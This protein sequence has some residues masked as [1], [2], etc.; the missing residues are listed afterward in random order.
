M[1]TGRIT[2]AA[3]T[4]AF[5]LAP[6]AL[7]AQTVN[8][9]RLPG[10][11]T[12]PNPKAQGP[13]DPDAP[14]L[15]TTP[16]PS[17]T[18]TV[19][20]SIAP[21]PVIVPSAAPSHAPAQPRTVVKQARP[22]TAPASSTPVPATTAPP[23]G[24]SP[25]VVAPLPIPSAS[26]STLPPVAGASSVPAAATSDLPDWLPWL[27]GGLGLLLLGGAAGY[28][29]RR[30]KEPSE[31]GAFEPAMISDAAPLPPSTTVPRAAPLPPPGPDKQAP[32]PAPVQPVVPAVAVANHAAKLEIAL[33]ATRMIASLMA[34]TLNYRLVVTNR[35]EHPLSALAIEGDMVSAHASLPPDRQIASDGNRLELRHALVALAPG[36]SAEFTGDFRLPLGEVTP[37]RAGTAT[38]FVPLARLRV[39]ASTPEGGPM[40]S[41]QTFVVGELPENPGAALRPFR[42]DLGPRTYSRLGQRA[43]N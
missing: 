26:D 37:I 13:V 12:A 28:A 3:G 31:D 2:A 10:A 21:A 30:R 14:A 22:A 6:A 1:R 17:A 19:A 4:L 38:Y 35:S 15:R 36:E 11:T 18:P 7:F 32:S 42:L 16:Q 8:D 27:G 33:E 25:A 23:L 39:E 24:Q 43:V 9:Y 40:V 20:P 34:T 41:V 5:A 29:L